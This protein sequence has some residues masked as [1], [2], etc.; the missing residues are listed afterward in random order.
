M[1]GRDALAL[2]QQEGRKRETLARLKDGSCDIVIGTHR[3]LSK[4]VHFKRLGLLVVDEEQRFGVTHKERIKKLRTEVDVLTLTAT[5]IPRT[6]QMAIGGLRDLSLITTPPARSAR[7]PHLRHALGRPRDPRGDPA[8]A[9]RAADRC[10]SSTT[11]SRACT[12]APRACSSW[13]PRRASRVAHGQMREGAL[14]QTM[15]DFVEGRYD[16]LACTAI[17]ES[18][19]DIPRANTI[20]I[21]RADMFGLSQL[22][23]LR[24]RVGRSRERAYCYLI[25]PPPSQMTDEARTRIEALERFTELGVGLPGR[26]ARHGAARRGRPARRRA[27]RDLAA[28]RLRPVLHMLEEAVAR[29]ARRARRARRRPRADARRRALLPDDYVA[30]VGVRLSLY[31]RLAAAPTTKTRCTSSRPRWKTASARRPAGA[32]ARARHAAQA[33]AAQRCAS[34]GCE[35]SAQRVTLHLRDDTPLDIAKLT[36]LVSRTRGFQLTPDGKLICRFELE[37]GKGAIERA[38]S[39][40][41]ALSP[42]HKTQ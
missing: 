31:K 39:V 22:Y 12:S 10:S 24:G 6:L 2:R 8:R 23:Q 13:C 27:E 28:G 21:D 25:V 16:V 26:V 19:L 20:F 14:E 9:R 3:L 11:A 38:R 1:Q 15:L 30:D 7:D 33:R 4:D 40:L 36:A 37:P 34:L 32:A 18:G 42:V 41:Q 17:I 29:A 5:P 35:A